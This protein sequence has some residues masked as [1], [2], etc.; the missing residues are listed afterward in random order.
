M[1]KPSHMQNANAAAVRAMKVNKEVD[2]QGDKGLEVIVGQIRDII[3]ND[4]SNQ[5]SFVTD[6]LLA[7]SIKKDDGSWR[8][9]KISPSSSLIL[10]S[11]RIGSRGLI[12]GFETVDQNLNSFHC[13]VPLSRAEREIPEFKEVLMMELNLPQP[14]GESLMNDVRRKAIEL[15]MR[16]VELEVATPEPKVRPQAW[17]TW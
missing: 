17:G 15:K 5:L 16:T 6:K 8:S 10:T 9:Q 4:T 13:E 12:M 3:T 2:T 1:R 11:A 14:L 7:V